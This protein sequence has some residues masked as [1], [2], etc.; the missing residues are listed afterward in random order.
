MINHK[1]Y[2]FVY[3]YFKLHCKLTAERACWTITQMIKQQSDETEILSL[4]LHD[5]HLSE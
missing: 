1:F 5:E 2:T 3:L 4:L